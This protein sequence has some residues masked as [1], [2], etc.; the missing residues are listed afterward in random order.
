MKK[1]PIDLAVER[2]RRSGTANMLLNDVRRHIHHKDFA[3]AE[4]ELKAA[5]RIERTAE[6]AGLRLLLEQAQIEHSVVLGLDP[7]LRP[8]EVYSL[9]GL[10]RT[11]VWQRVSRGE[12]PAPVSLGAHV[13]A[14]RR[15]AIKQWMESRP[16]VAPSA[17]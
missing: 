10:G 14:W 9:T 4:R 5:E 3:E 13:I 15:S 6:T 7:L 1:D 8:R 16:T 17:A 2:D 12:F 11:A